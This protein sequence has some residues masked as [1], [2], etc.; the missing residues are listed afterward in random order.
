MICAKGL[1]NLW[2][3]CAWTGQH[4]VEV[5]WTTPMEDHNGGVGE[6]NYSSRYELELDNSQWVD[7]SSSH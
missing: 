6:L 4:L 3:N 1:E 2:K 7:D 5:L